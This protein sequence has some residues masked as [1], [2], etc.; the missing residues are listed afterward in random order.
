MSGAG[1]DI[2]LIPVIGILPELQALFYNKWKLE[3]NQT[4]PNWTEWNQSECNESELN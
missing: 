3:L 1:W 2:D 4:K